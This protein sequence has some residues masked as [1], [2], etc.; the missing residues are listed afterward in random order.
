MKGTRDG[1][2][3]FMQTSSS[4]REFLQTVVQFFQQHSKDKVKM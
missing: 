1:K 4:P 2:L 3:E